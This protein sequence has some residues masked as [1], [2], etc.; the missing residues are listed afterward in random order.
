MKASGFNRALVRFD[1]NAIL[2]ALGT[3]PATSAILELYVERNGHNWGPDGRT[4]EAHR[5]TADWSEL[6]A[7]WHCASDTSTG[8]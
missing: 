3:D 8:N 2:S 6:G 1:A 4:V 5:L 7:T